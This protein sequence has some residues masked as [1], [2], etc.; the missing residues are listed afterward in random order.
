MERIT[1][2]QVNKDRTEAD[3]AEYFILRQTKDQKREYDIACD[4]LKKAEAFVRAERAKVAELRDVIIPQ[5]VIDY[6]DAIS[7]GRKTKELKAKTKKAES[8]LRF[9]EGWLR[10][11]NIESN[12]NL[13]PRYAPS[14]AENAIEKATTAMN[15]AKNE[16]RNAMQRAYMIQMDKLSIRASDAMAI[17]FEAFEDKWRISQ[18]CGRILSGFASPVPNPVQV[19]DFIASIYR[20]QGKKIRYQKMCSILPRAVVA[21]KHTFERVLKEDRAKA[22]G[23][24]NR[25]YAGRLKAYISSAVTTFKANN[26]DGDF[27]SAQ[28]K[29]NIK[30]IETVARAKFLDEFPKEPF[31]YSPPQQEVVATT[32]P[33]EMYQDTEKRVHEIATKA[34]AKEK[35]DIAAGRIQP[36]TKRKPNLVVTESTGFAKSKKEKD[37][38]REKAAIKAAKSAPSDSDEY[39]RG[40]TARDMM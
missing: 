10:G 20:D 23:V 29:E 39:A 31:V 18:R 26:P 3:N 6:N 14:E 16:Y 27:R 25:A 22:E 33:I 5:L 37:I 8:D 17:L 1:E 40:L 35:A 7:S 34:Y 15:T 28:M 13:K 21:G 12:L 36:Q 9:A 38:E 30:A 11:K 2:L 32:D 19:V 4:N 24:H